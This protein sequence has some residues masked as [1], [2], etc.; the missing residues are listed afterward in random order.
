MS[1][2]RRTK[3]SFV[4]VRVYHGLIYILSYILQ[5]GYVQVCSERASSSQSQSFRSCRKKI[6][7]TRVYWVTQYIVSPIRLA[8]SK[9]SRAAAHSLQGN[10]SCKREMLEADHSMEHRFYNA[11]I[12]R[13]DQEERCTG[14]EVAIYR[15]ES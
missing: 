6:L 14:S 8:F 15:H 9:P 3:S 10:N 7:V 12:R 11:V 5:S 1:R 13:N 2:T 4:N